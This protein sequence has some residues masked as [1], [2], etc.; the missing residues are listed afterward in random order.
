M[1]TVYER[2]DDDKSFLSRHL[3]TVGDGT[4]SHDGNVDGRPTEVGGP[5][6]V[7]F[8]INAPADGTHVIHRL[9]V[10]LEDGGNFQTSTYGARASLSLGLRI[11]YFNTT[12]NTIIDDFTSTQPIQT[13]FDWSLFAYPATLNAWGGTNQ[14]LVAIWDFAEDG[15]SLHLNSLQPERCFGVEVR[16]DLTGLVAHEF[17]AYGYTI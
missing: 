3:D 15:C 10:V 11:G 1:A 12:T 5:G 2:I 14:H 13:N 4:G 9:H 16:D 7:L 17:V 6:E 8:K